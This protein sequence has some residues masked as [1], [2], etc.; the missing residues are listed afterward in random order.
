[1]YSNIYIVYMY[2]LHILIEHLY[3]IY[4]Y[5]SIYNSRNTHN[6]RVSPYLSSNLEYNVIEQFKL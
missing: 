1:M 3:E 6:G 2:S 5:K 4:G